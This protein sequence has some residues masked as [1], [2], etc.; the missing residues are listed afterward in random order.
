MIHISPWSIA[1]ACM[2]LIVVA[3]IAGVAITRARRLDRLH[4]RILASRDALSRLLLR[5]ASEAE[6]LAHAARLESGGD[7]GLVDAARA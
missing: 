5:R 2:C 3:L 1:L 6:L 7:P 4:Q